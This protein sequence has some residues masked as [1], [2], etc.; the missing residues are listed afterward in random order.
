MFAGRK[1]LIATKHKKELVLSPILEKEL[2][3]SCFVSEQFDTDILGTF[4]G[5]I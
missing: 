1:V 4:S 5:E 3:V 2:V